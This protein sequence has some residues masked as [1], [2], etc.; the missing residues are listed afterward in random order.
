M[1]HVVGQRH[2][3]LGIPQ[4]EIGIGAD[5]DGPLPGVQ[6]VE[7]GRVGRRDRDEGLQ[8]DAPGHDA[9]GEHQRQAVLDSRQ[10]RADLVEVELARGLLAPARALHAVGA[11]VRGDELEDAVLDAAP[12]VVRVLRIA[13]R[14]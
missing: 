3:A 8:V 14:R 9:F 13:R 2:L 5:R 4:H 1:Q 11:V 7:L 10:A 6:A 12:Q